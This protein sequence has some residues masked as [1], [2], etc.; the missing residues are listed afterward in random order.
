MSK[1][2]NQQVIDLIL[3][4]IQKLRREKRMKDNNNNILHETLYAWNV[5]RE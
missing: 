1:I 5:V 2:F 3:I 4:S